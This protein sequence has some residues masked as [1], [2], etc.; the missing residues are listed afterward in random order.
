MTTSPPYECSVCYKNMKTKQR[1]LIHFR[2]HTGE[3]PFKCE[4]CSCAYTQM[5]NL[6]THIKR[7]HP[8]A[9]PEP[10]GGRMPRKPSQKVAMVVGGASNPPTVADVNTPWK[11]LVAC[12]Q[13]ARKA[14]TDARAAS[15]APADSKLACCDNTDTDRTAIIGETSVVNIAKDVVGHDASS[16]PTDLALSRDFRTGD[17]HGHA[18]EQNVATVVNPVPEQVNPVPEVNPNAEDNDVEGVNDAKGKGLEEAVD[19]GCPPPGLVA[20]LSRQ[21]AEEE[22]VEEESRGPEATAGEFRM[23][24]HCL[25]VLFVVVV[26]FSC[27]IWRCHSCGFNVIAFFWLIEP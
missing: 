11:T 9:V 8:S 25:A 7:K 17:V 21:L 22:A 5:G 16:F 27:S 26:D 15:D 2:V 12:F 18:T 23:I 4:L 3:R 20:P 19:L 6:Q 1:L 24:N 13:G 14:L 10:S